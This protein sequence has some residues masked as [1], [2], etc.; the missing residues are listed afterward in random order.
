[1]KKADFPV[2][3]AIASLRWGDTVW[4]AKRGGLS[5]RGIEW[6]LREGKVYL[7]SETKTYVIVVGEGLSSNGE[8]V[9]ARNILAFRKGGEKTLNVIFG[10]TDDI[11][12]VA[13]LDN[14]KDGKFVMPK[15]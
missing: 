6:N 7:P 8:F 9:D 5:S 4:F 3:E 10:D 11:E 2:S 14:F 15:A 13:H 12:R 1:M